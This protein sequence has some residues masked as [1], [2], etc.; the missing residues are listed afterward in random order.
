MLPDVIAVSSGTISNVWIHHV[1]EHQNSEVTH[2]FVKL[3]MY[4]MIL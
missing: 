4:Q 2:G 1:Q 3:V